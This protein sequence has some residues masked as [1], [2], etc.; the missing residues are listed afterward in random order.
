MLLRENIKMHLQLHRMFPLFQSKKLFISALNQHNNKVLFLTA[1]VID[2]HSTICIAN[3]LAMTDCEENIKSK[4]E[5]L[6]II[7]K[8]MNKNKVIEVSAVT[9]KVEICF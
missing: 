6:S 7:A 5:R 4:T 8:D 1:G 9:G 2:S 3:K